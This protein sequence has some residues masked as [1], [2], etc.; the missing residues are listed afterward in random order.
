MKTL[1]ALLGLL[2]F[3]CG[4]A[5]AQGKQDPNMRQIHRDLSP[6]TSSSSRMVSHHSSRGAMPKGSVAA[7]ANAELTK[8]EQN[9]AKIAVTK[10]KPLPPSAISLPKDDSGK[11]TRAG[12]RGAPPRHKEQMATN[13]SKGS[14]RIGAKPGRSR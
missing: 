4:S 6:K 3:F 13:N 9:S 10:P 12:L 8:L 14:S 2:T 5:L 1:F 11:K 7:S